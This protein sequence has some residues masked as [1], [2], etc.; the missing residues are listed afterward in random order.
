MTPTS[1]GSSVTSGTPPSSLFFFIQ[2]NLSSDD[3]YAILVS[4]SEPEATSRPHTFAADGTGL[5]RSLIKSD[6]G[7]IQLWS[8]R[9]RTAVIF[10]KDSTRLPHALHNLIP[11]MPPLRN[12][13]EWIC[14][15]SQHQDRCDTLGSGSG[16]DYCRHR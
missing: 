3:C 10:S 4:P 1:T 6:Q 12:F 16:G 13:L 9:A 11:W 15:H 5:Y 2:V 8:S 7:T 14:C